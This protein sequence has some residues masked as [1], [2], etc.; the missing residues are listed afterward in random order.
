MSVHLDNKPNYYELLCLE[1]SATKEDVKKA[2]RKQALLFHPD[3]MRPHMK[4]EASAHFQLISEAYEVLSDGV[5]AGGDPNPQPQANF[6]VPVG[7][8]GFGDHPLFSEFGMPAH[9]QFFDPF[10]RHQQ[11]NQAAFGPFGGF[12]QPQVFANHFQHHH[13]FQNPFE[14]FHQQTQPT[15]FATS[16]FANRSQQSGWSGTGTSDNPI[17]ETSSSGFSFSSSFSGG[18]GGGG[19]GGGVRRSTRTTV[20]NGMRTTVTEVTDAQGVTTRTVEKSDGTRETFVNGVPSRIEGSS[21]QQ[22]QGNGRNNSKLQPIV[23]LDEEDSSSSGK[24][25]N[26][27]N[28]S[29]APSHSE[30]IVLDTDDDEI[31]YED[32]SRD[33]ARH[34]TSDRRSYQN[35]QAQNQDNWDDPNLYH[36]QMGRGQSKPADASVKPMKKQWLHIN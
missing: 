2:Y 23:I 4:E 21:S 6:N 7:P 30:T 13:N 16:P 12:P 18:S 27:L 15:L 33:R 32:L 22:A 34:Q 29:S 3:K 26:N 8:Q 11:M 25:G 9:P 31:M 14:H 35:Q 28:G 1:T 17:S 20:V 10:V 5:K 19:G 24:S 36:P